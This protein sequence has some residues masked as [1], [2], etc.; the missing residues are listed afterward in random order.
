[1]RN[2]GVEE[3]YQQKG[4]KFADDLL[5]LPC[6]PGEYI[7]YIEVEKSYLKYSTNENNLFINCWSTDP[8]QLEFIEEE[9]G[10]L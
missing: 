1:M 2:D 6:L 4:D 7:L 10:V 5:Y 8:T 3:V 9:F